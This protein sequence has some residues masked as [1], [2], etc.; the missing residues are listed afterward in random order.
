MLVF[1]PLEDFQ[2]E[3]S[4]DLRNEVSVRSVLSLLAIS[5]SSANGRTSGGTGSPMLTFLPSK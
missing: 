4:W 2:W 5:L 3:P 1:F